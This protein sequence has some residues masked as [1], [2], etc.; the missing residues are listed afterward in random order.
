MHSYN[1]VLLNYTCTRVLPVATTLVSGSTA[2]LPGVIGRISGLALL[3]VT[4]GV[5][6]ALIVVLRKRK[7]RPTE[8]K[9]SLFSVQESLESGISSASNTVDDAPFQ[10]PPEQLGLT[11][12]EVGLQYRPLPPKP[13]QVIGG[14]PSSVDNIV[15]T[16]NNASAEDATYATLSYTTSA[17]VSVP[18][19][20]NSGTS[21]N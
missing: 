14:G 20:P 10:L 12:Q 11:Q 19:Y 13:T 2:W 7:T 8:P 6:T 5:M 3:L 9:R 18:R 1:R 4:N 17:D 16:N 15:G 21:A